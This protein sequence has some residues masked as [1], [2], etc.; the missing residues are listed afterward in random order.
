M[1]L[2]TQVSLTNES[3]F[4]NIRTTYIEIAMST[5]DPA[6]QAFENAKAA[7]RAKLKDK[8]LFQ[9]LLQTTSIEQ[10]W[11]TTNEIQTRQEVEKRMRFMGKIKT[12]L[13]KLSDYASVVDTFVQVKPDVMALIWGPIRLLLLWTANVAKLADAIVS[14]TSRIGDV[15]PPFLETVKIFSDSE[16][17]KNVLALFFEDILDFY[18]IL[19]EF[20]KL[21]RRQFLFESIWPKQRERVKVV[22]ES[23]ERHGSLLRNEA[24]LQQIKAEHEARAKALAHFDETSNFQELQKFQA[25]RNYI[26]PDTH[27]HRLDWLLNRSCKGSTE[28]LKHNETYL[29]WLDTSKSAVKLLWL[30]GIPG[31]GKTFLAASVLEEVKTLHQTCFIFATYARQH[32]TTARSILQ[33]LIFQ[34]A[35]SN[36]DLQSV[37]IHS[38]EREL[39]TSTKCV[40]ALFKTFLKAAGPT[41]L[42]L[43]GLD[44]IERSERTILLQLI[45]EL[46]VFPEIKILIT[47]RPE[48][49]IAKVLDLQASGIRV[50]KCNSESLK[51]YIDQRT[52]AWMQD[53]DFD[54]EAQC[55]IQ[56]LLSPLIKRANGMFLFVRIVL[57]NVESLND[58][59][60]IQRELRA[61]PLNLHDAYGRIFTQINNSPPPLRHKARTIL[62]WIGCAPVPMTRQEME[63]ALLIDLGIESAPCVVTTVNFVRICGPIVE[64]VDDTP[65]FVHFTVKEYIFSQEIS[66]FILHFEAECSLAKALLEYLCSGIYDESLTEDQL[67]SSILA[68]RYRLHCGFTSSGGY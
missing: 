8:D 10:V 25:L 32:N 1:E 28:W 19:L 5:F 7:F 55:Q 66:S 17:L 15:L 39:A 60:E 14:A 64:L 26:S 38:D 2:P 3:A 45:V 29:A 53:A 49:D 48:D 52:H 23:I 42:V 68:G 20:F 37:L 21:S 13:D 4:L 58:F 43:D 44:E 57:D 47:S 18:A 61:L 30:R 34:L 46:K 41:Y 56:S 31:A 50:D 63:Q 27:G 33:S 67:Q 16:R 9:Q 36:K 51:S 24:T 54:Q 6:R 22:V 59:R 11:Q 62:G 35:S 40:S 12:F 65:Q